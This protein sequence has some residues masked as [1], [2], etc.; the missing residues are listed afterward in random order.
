MRYFLDLSY[1]GTNYHGWQIQKNAIT[2]QEEVDRVLSI[3]LREKT[4]CVGSGRTDT[5]VHARQQ[6][7]HFDS[8]GELDIGEFQFRMNRMLGRDISVN[9]MRKVKPEANARFDAIKREY[10]YHIH[11]RKDPFREKLSYY[12]SA[13]LDHQVLQEGMEILRRWTDFQC[14][15]RVKTDVNHFECEIAHIRWDLV[16]YCYCFSVSANRFLR[17]MV[18]SMVGTLLEMGTGRLSPEGLAHI[19]E[20]RDRKLAGRAVPA[21][22]LYLQAVDYPETL[23]LD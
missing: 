7:A 5:G 13:P 9:G 19:L 17:G 10:H 1:K 23:F 12:F 21:E 6:I 15:S 22:G 8:R 2:V 20:S 16:N 3:L 4:I 14:F 11:T 18:R